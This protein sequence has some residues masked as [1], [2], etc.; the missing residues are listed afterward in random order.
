MAS[1]A[2]RTIAAIQ[3]RSAITENRNGNGALRN[4]L[5]SPVSMIAVRR[6]ARTTATTQD[7]TAMKTPS[8]TT[9][10]R[11]VEADAPIALITPNSRVRSITFALIVELS[12]IS[13]TTPMTEATNR[14]TT[15]ST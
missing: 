11:T 3:A 13:P 14:K 10:R 2:P 5:P 4:R 12:P 1:A 9:M 6:R 15:T 8:A 7:E